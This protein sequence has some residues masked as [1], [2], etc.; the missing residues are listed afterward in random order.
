MMGRFPTPWWGL[1]LTLVLIG[2]AGPVSAEVSRLRISG[3]PVAESLVFAV[4]AHRNMVPVSFIPWQSP[5]QARAMI[6]GGQVDASIVTTSAAAIFFNRKMP[7]RIAGV[8]DSPLWVVSVRDRAGGLPLDG[9]L[10]FPF[11]HREMPEMLFETVFG[12]TTPN[13]ER[14]HAG[15]A[16][17]AV[18][19]MLLA[20][21]HHA[22]LAEPGASLAVLKS[23][24]QG[25]PE[26]VKHVDMRRAWQKRFGGM[27]LYVSSLAVFGRTLDRPDVIQ[28]VVRAYPTARQ[29]MMDHPDQALAIAR[30]LTPAVAAQVPSPE[31]LT[32]AGRLFSGPSDFDAALFFLNQLHERFPGAA[33]D[34]P[35]ARA[36]FLGTE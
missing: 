21:G 15:G 5:D 26:L 10:F 27:P 7:V 8:F 24:K 30:E 33:G 23:Q 17:E 9:V 20:R 18:N 22:L 36:M 29:W 35:P 14:R 2:M 4:M 19:L 3:P 16:L 1:I 12:Q 34:R 31:K 13:L 25:C 28:R 6:A 32:P 11:G